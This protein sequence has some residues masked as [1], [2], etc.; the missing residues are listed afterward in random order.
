MFA[1]RF[2][3]KMRQ[4]TPH[5]DILILKCAY[6]LQKKINIFNFMHHI[7]LL[8]VKNDWVYLMDLL[9]FSNSSTNSLRINIRLT[10]TF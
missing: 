8:I 6:N 9:I 4:I 3:D 10:V 5:N 7:K 2:I 1:L